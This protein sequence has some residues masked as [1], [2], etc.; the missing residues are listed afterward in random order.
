MFLFYLLIIFVS[1]YVF[2]FMGDNKYTTT[3]HRKSNKIKNKKTKRI[4]KQKSKVDAVV[5]IEDIVGKSLIPSVMKEMKKNGVVPYTLDEKK[6]KVRELDKDE[7]F[8]TFR[9]VLNANNVEKSFSRLRTTTLQ[10]N[11]G[12]FCNQACSHCHVDS[13]PIRKEM[14]NRDITERIVEIVKNS[15]SIKTIDI[16]GGAP[17][18]NREFKFLVESFSDM[19]IEIIDRCNLTVLLEPNQQYLPTY[20]A[21]H[22]VRVIAS[23]PCYLKDN[24][25]K[26]RGEQIFERSIKGIQM[27]NDVGYGRENSGL[28]LDLVYN[29]TGIHLP[30]PKENLIHDYKSFLYEHFQIEFNDLHCITNIPINRYYDYLKGEEK[31]LEYMNILVNSFNPNAVENLMCR[32]Y[33]SIDPKGKLFDCDFNQQTD[34]DLNN[35]TVWDI[36]ST[37][38]ILDIPI[39]SHKYCFGCTAGCGS[40]C[41]QD[42]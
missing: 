27:L 10:L 30:P 31:V 20:L 35:K 4:Q 36:L 38:D 28:Q 1:Y 17:E 11:I 15:P 39:S 42:D 13:S 37:D 16:T 18:L 40:S 32:S 7:R 22:K 41:R 14:M 3:K 5:D 34:V 2:F 12:Y 25:A 8:P 26:Q 6:E 24:V 19:G 33:I 9:S 23:L 29:P 21:K